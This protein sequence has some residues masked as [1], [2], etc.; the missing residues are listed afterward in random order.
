MTI[1]R[2]ARQETQKQ[3][4]RQAILD[5][6][7][8]LFASSTYQEMTLEMVAQHVGVARGTIYLYFKTRE[9]LFLVAFSDLFQSWLDE[10]DAELQRIQQITDE[11][12]RIEEVARLIPE[13][14]AQ[15]K[16]MVR[17]SSVVHTILE[18]NIDL[19]RARQFK[20]EM[21]T[22][23]HQTAHLLEQCLPFLDPDQ[24][25]QL[26]IYTDTLIIGLSQQ[27]EHAPVLQQVFA[28]PDMQPLLVNFQPAF[29]HL[30]RVLLYGLEQEKLRKT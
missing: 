25:L 20:K 2:R 28:E 8:Q 1:L 30:F 18:H 16:T 27:S 15:R 17:I 24:G 5:T 3:E 19:E 21:L 11:Q 7:L 29:S 12:D 10:V 6:A 22:R 9:E 23:A 14:L 4:R 26:L 13:S